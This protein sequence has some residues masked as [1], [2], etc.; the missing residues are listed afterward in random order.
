MP[1]PG[2]TDYTDNR[3]RY[4]ISE[5]NVNVFFPT[6]LSTDTQ[7]QCLSLAGCRPRGAGLKSA[8]IWQGYYVTDPVKKLKYVLQHCVVFQVSNYFW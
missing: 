7:L 8:L 1:N 5:E 3:V 6:A 4:I 2:Y